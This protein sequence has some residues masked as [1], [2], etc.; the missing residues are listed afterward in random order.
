MAAVSY[1]LGAGGNLQ[2]V[3]TGTTAPGSAT[4]AVS[5]FTPVIQAVNS[6]LPNQPVA[7]SGDMGTISGLSVDVVYYVSAIGLSSSTFQ[8]S[9]TPGGTPIT[10]SA[11]AQNTVY[12]TVSLAG[13]IQLSIDQTPVGITD[14][15]APGGARALKR[16]EIFTM[17]VTLAQAL[18][19]DQT[20]NQ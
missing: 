19:Q 14:A 20:L 15:N 18:L 9:A 2:S 11:S 16:G 8:V 4:T 6:F 12:P 13:Y 5:A 17:L 10:P 7:F 3:T 1:L